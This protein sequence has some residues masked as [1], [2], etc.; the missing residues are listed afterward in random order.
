MNEIVN[1]YFPRSRNDRLD[2]LHACNYFTCPVLCN[3]VAACMSWF[4][5]LSVFAAFSLVV[6]ATEDS[7]TTPNTTS[8]EEVF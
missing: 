8:T 1:C 3:L 5:L 2:V 7:T 4:Y 6:S